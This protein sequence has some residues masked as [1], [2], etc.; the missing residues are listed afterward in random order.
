MIPVACGRL[1]LKR[2]DCLPSISRPVRWSLP[3]ARSRSG[4]DHWYAGVR[5]CWH[6]FAH[7]CTT[8]CSHSPNYTCVE[9][10]DRTRRLGPARQFQ[11][12]DTL[13]MEVALVEGKE[14]FAWP[15]SK[16]FESDDLRTLIS[17][18]SLRQRSTSRSSRAPSFFQRAGL[19]LS[20]RR[21]GQ[22][23]APW[24]ATIFALHESSAATRSAWTTAPRWFPIMAPSGRTR[25]RWMRPGW[26]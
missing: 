10:M 11:M 26:K 15:G 19:C 16:K 25:R 14:M 6:E 8:F 12:Q 4:P 13:R 17:G 3:Q 18:G 20:R 24:S 7:T 21:P 1:A 2:K 5:H 23:A 22:R 9:T